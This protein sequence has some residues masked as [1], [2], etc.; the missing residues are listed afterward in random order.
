MTTSSIAHSSWNYRFKIYPFLYIE[1]LNYSTFKHIKRKSLFGSII[2]TN[3][4][5]LLIPSMRASKFKIP[6][7]PQEIFKIIQVSS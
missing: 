4:P 2:I 1:Y 7:S 5:A 3:Q 6:S